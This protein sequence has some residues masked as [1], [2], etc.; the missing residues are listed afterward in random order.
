MV[1]LK[2]SILALR[3]PELGEPIVE[4]VVT[5][6]EAFG[7]DHH[8]DV[9]DL[10]IVFRDDLGVLESCESDEVGLIEVPLYHP[11]L[12]RTGDHTTVSRLWVEGPCLAPANN[13]VR[14]N[15]LD[16]GPTILSLLGVPADDL[17]DRPIDLVG[18]AT[19]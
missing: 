5:A 6:A 11:K 7:P 10:M 14:A 12:P 9:P 3:H 16:I 15:V 18:S 19:A 4:R 8:P 13:S 17:D 2:Q 1:K